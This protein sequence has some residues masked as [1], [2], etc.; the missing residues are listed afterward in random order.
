MK[1]IYLDN[2]STSYPKAPP[3]A[4]AMTDYLE[5]NG[6]NLNR[7]EHA[8][9][10]S[11]E[12]MVNHAR[13]LVAKLFCSDHEELV[14]F[15]L[16]ATT[17]INTLIT[18]LFT[19]KDHVIISPFEH[20]A[21]LRPLV[22]HQIPYSVMGCKGTEIDYDSIASLIKP[23]TKAI[24][25]QGASNVSGQ[26]HDLS[27][28]SEI[29]QTHHLLFL[30]DSAQSAPTIPL[31]IAT[32]DAI[33][34]AGHKGLL[35]PQGTGG[36][37][38]TPEVAGH[39]PPFIMGGTGSKSDSFLMPT[40]CPDKFEAGTQNIPGLYGLEASLR[41]LDEN[42]GLSSVTKARNKALIE[43]IKG[44][45]GLHLINTNPDTPITAITSTQLDIG[46]LCEKIEDRGGIESRVGL[47]CAPLAHQSLGT[48]PTGVLRLSPGWTTTPDEIEETITIL[49]EVTHALL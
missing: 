10:F 8:H 28:L 49:K 44:I 38:L 39:L 1:R 43:G 30:I 46:I 20:N 2:A 24:I 17:A 23:E 45:K 27:L 15:T 14:T 13:H 7:G 36:L 19:P 21:V 42:P 33:A 18:G 9:T 48:F 34:F 6:A 12:D 40:F 3:V 41:Y 4:Q 29:A 16:N 32:C 26:A 47:Q 35:G 11:A 37:V 5:H 25:C 22:F 31:S